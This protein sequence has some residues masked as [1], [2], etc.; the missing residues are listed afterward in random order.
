MLSRLAE[1]HG[2]LDIEPRFHGSLIPPFSCHAAPP[3]SA[4]PCEP[5]ARGAPASPEALGPSARRDGTKAEIRSLDQRLQGSGPAPERHRG[6]LPRRRLLRE[7]RPADF[8]SSALAA[9]DP[10]P[11][12]VRQLMRRVLG[13]QAE[14]RD[15]ARIVIPEWLTGDTEQLQP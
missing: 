2:L 8:V 14:P 3:R 13:H 1:R 11:E 9:G 12:T 4:R 6:P 5:F 7:Q 15:D 10:A